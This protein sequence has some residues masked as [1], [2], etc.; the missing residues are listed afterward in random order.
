MN[1]T[2]VTVNTYFS[3]SKVVDLYIVNKEQKEN[4]S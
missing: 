4:V 2:N 3:K 1:Y